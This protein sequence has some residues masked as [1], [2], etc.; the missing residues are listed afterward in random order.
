[1]VH[2]KTSEKQMF[3]NPAVKSCICPHTHTREGPAQ[4]HC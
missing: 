4:Q 3:L 2:L 1:M